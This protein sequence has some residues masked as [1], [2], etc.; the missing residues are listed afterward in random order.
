MLRRNF[1]VRGELDASMVS[2][3]LGPVLLGVS[4]TTH[5]VKFRTSVGVVDFISMS[6]GSSLVKYVDAGVSGILRKII[7]RNK[8]SVK[9]LEGMLRSGGVEMVE[10]L[11]EGSRTFELKK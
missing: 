4:K 8:G 10:I 1:L 2:A 3:I 11:S 7:I 6:L 5:K 9:V